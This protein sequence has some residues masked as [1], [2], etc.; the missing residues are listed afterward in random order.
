MN[1]NYEPFGGANDFDYYDYMSVKDA[2]RSVSR[3]TLGLFLFSAVSTVLLLLTFVILLIALGKDGYNALATNP[4]FYIPMGTLFAYVTGFPLLWLCIRSLPK[5]R[6]KRGNSLSV[7]EIIAIIPITQFASNIGSS[8]GLGVDGVFR[9][10]FHATSTNPVDML[11]EGVPTWLI[12]VVTVIIVPILEE[13]VFRKLILD[14][15][16]VY[17]NIFAIIMSAA[18]FGLYH[19]NF[20]QLFYAFMLGLIAG[21]VTVKGGSWLWGVALHIF[22]NFTNGALPTMLEGHFENYEAAMLAFVN[23]DGD[24]F[25][26]NFDSFMIAGSYAIIIS[27][28]SVAGAIILVYAVTKRLIRIN[29]APEAAIPLGK[30]PLVIFLNVGM[31]LFL[32]YSAFSI[33]SQYLPIL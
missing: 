10:I 2:K 4:Y 8:I 13:F 28:L 11:T 22:V 21:Y 31:L 25:V 7:A 16:S 18:L 3:T 24:A 29:N 15:L 30:L 23:G 1:Y 6:Y 17:G 12:I 14:R 32:L 27:M 20:Y 33:I 19:G 5:R 26:E 9:D